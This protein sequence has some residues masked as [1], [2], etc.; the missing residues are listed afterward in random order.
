MRALLLL[1]I[2]TTPVMAEDVAVRDRNGNPL[3]HL[4]NQGDRTYVRDNAGNPHGYYTPGGGGVEFRTNA[5]NLV[6][7]S[8]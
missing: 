8:K 2:F 5:G 3:Y 7:R 6:T 1:L 4:Q